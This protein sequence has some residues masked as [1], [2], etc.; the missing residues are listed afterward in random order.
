MIE[1]EKVD[2]G[3]NEIKSI[4]PTSI[5]S[6]MIIKLRLRQILQEM[7]KVYSLSD[8]GEDLEFETKGKFNFLEL[9]E[10]IEK[11]YPE[12]NSEKKNFLL[13]FIPLTSIGV[14]KKTPFINLL[15][16]FTFFE[17]I[18]EEKIISSSFIFYKTIKTLKDKYRISPSEFIYSMGLYTSSVLNLKEFYIK[19]ASKL[20]LDDIDSM[21]IFNGLDTRSKNTLLS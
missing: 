7:N 16:L 6:R 8:F 4:Y 21:L 11:K 2:N 20:N 14:N 3:I 17:K 12:L 9:K 19:I 18:L 10:I 5:K 13:K 15:N 1:E